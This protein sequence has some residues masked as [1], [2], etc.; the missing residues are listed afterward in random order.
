MG[1]QNDDAVTADEGTIS[2][3]AQNI[4]NSDSAQDDPVLEEVVEEA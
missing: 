4:L 1:E 2:E 3:A